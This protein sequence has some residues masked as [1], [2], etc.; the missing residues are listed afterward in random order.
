MKDAPGAQAAPQQSWEPC[1]T[2]VADGLPAADI[3][4]TADSPQR[5]EKV[6]SIPAHPAQVA[7]QDCCA[8]RVLA[9]WPLPC[10]HRS[11][12]ALAVASAA[13]CPS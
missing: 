3:T 1:T 8:A 13:A 5:A 9:N 12:A 7:L 10:S 6:G 2:A 4:A 11:C